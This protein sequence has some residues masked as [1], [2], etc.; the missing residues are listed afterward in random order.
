MCSFSTGGPKDKVKKVDFIKSELASNPEFFK[1]FPHLEK[2]SLTD[3]DFLEAAEEISLT[4]NEE[5]TLKARYTV[6]KE[7]NYFESL[8]WQ[9]TTDK[10]TS[11]KD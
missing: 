2:H 10:D 8:L 9:Y 7:E 1:A 6:P 5:T 3:E 4:P 11:T